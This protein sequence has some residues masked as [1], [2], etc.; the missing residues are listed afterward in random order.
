MS[1]TRCLSHSNSPGKK[2][3]I[4][5]FRDILQIMWRLWKEC[6]TYLSQERKWW[7]VPL[8]ISLLT[9]AVLIIFAGSSVLAPFVY[10]FF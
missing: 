8:V 5:V 7:L 4:L 6:L 2:L 3:E 10:S 9:I 1:S